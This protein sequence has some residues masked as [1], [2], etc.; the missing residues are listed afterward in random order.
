MNGMTRDE[1]ICAACSLL[2]CLLAC[3]LLQV[4][5]TP[6]EVAACGIIGTLGLLAFAISIGVWEW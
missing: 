5:R 6:T 4:A 3:V 1:I 2:E